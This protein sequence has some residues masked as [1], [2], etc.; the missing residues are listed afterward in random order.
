MPG[1]NRR[2]ARGAG[3]GLAVLL[4]AA[5]AFWYGRFAFDHAAALPD[6]YYLG[7]AVSVAAG[8]GFHAPVAAPGSPVD[9]FLSRRSMTLDRESA[10]AI[11]VEPPDAFHQTTRY[12]ITS[13]GYWWRMAGISWQATGQVAAAFHVLTV[14]GTY[15]L[16]RFF[17]PMP[18]A[19]IGALWT[20]TSTLHLALVPHIRDYSKGAFIV[21]A[22][23][24]IA[25]LALGAWSRRA[26]WVIAAAT[27]ALIGAGVGFKIDVLIMLPLAVVCVV[28]LRGSRPWQARVEKGQLIGLLLVAWLA[29]AGPVLARQSAGGSNLFHVI[30]LGFSDSFDTTLGIEKSVYAF[31]PFYSDDYVGR[32]IQGQSRTPIEL[33]SPGYDQVGAA[34][35]F[36]LLRTFPADMFTRGIAA[37]NEILN[38][39]FVG[40]D[41]S[42]LTRPLPGQAA[43]VGLYSAMNHGYGWG[44]LAGLLLVGIAAW[45][46]PRRGAFAALTMAVIAAYPS[47][48]FESRHYFHAQVVPLMALLA[49]LAA[50]VNVV[51][52]GRAAFDVRARAALLW[53]AAPIATALLLGLVLVAGLRSWQSASLEGAFMAYLETRAPLQAEAIPEAN[54]S[55]L[56]R[57]P[58]EQSPAGQAGVAAAHYVVEFNDAGKEPIHAAVRYDAETPGSDYSRVLSLPASTGTGRIGFSVFNVA[59]QSTFAGIELADS[60]KIRLAGVYRVRSGPA[61]L[62]LELRLPADWQQR[63]LYQRLRLERDEDSAVPPS[64]VCANGPG[65][66]G[67]LGYLDRAPVL[68]SGIAPETVGMIHSPAVEA[69]DGRI[70]IAGRVD[71]E[72][73]YLFQ[74]KEHVMASRGVFVAAGMLHEGGVAIGLLQNQVWYGQVF[75]RT[76]GPFLVLVPV[77]A[78]GTFVPL[79]TSAMPPGARRNRLSITR[80]GFIEAMP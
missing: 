40:R 3:E 43:L 55:W 27:G 23:P 20:C 51:K 54:G 36:G 49:L 64:V 31:L 80:A 44:L 19:V 72:S 75:L 78:P 53:V 67:L 39:C 45:N 52:R 35:F 32:I 65:C 71:A 24:C 41:P 63:A 16:V 70:D 68:I 77:N 11:T 4:L 6:Y 26:L 76:P 47:L 30:L 15:G 9:N 7:P 73:A 18:F 34:L 28:L 22:L 69:R 56:I 29:T 21:A 57:W 38:L 25:A 17:L 50:V 2:V 66:D 1:L 48:Q 74:L 33:F 37:A 60:A 10:A 14:I 13:V 5:A 59:G 8:K 12:L 46:H 79:V 61:G 62:P 58:Q 42:F